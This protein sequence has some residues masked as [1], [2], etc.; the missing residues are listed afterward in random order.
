VS[1]DTGTATLEPAAS[2]GA[3]ARKASGLV[4]SFSQTDALFYNILAINPFL[5]SALT[6]T[7]MVVAFPGASPWLAVLICGVLC[8][9][10]AVVYAYLTTM[11]PRSGGDYVFQSRVIGGAAAT[12][13]TLSGIVIAEIA[14]ILL[15]TSVGTSVIFAPFLTLLGAYY[16]SD[17]LT[18]VGTWLGTKAGFII[19]GGVVLLWCAY[20]NIR[21]LQ[22]YARVQRAVFVVAAGGLAAVFLI[23]LF[24][25]H[26]DFVNGL[27]SFMADH[28]GVHD[29][30]QTVLDRGSL[31]S[32]FSFSA[33]MTATVLAAF[34]F[35]FP[36]WGVMQAGEIKRAGATRGNMYA[37]LGAEIIS[38]GIALASVLLL[39]G[40]V[41]HD[42][43]IASGDLAFN[44]PGR[45]PLPVDPFF[46][47]FASVIHTSPA[48]AWLVFITAL[49]WFWMW[50]PNLLVAVTRVLLAL[51]FDRL[52]PAWLSQVGRRSHAPVNA[53]IATSVACLFFLI[54]YVFISD[55]I[56]LVAS[57]VMLTITT[58]AATMVAGGLMPWLRPD[59]FSRA[60]DAVQRRVLGLP[61]ITICAAIFFAYAVYVDYS[62]LTQDALGVNTTKG[63]VFVGGTYALSAAAYIAAVYYRRRQKIDVAVAYKEL[64]IE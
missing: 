8:I 20:I 45:N 1:E 46:G 50:V 59:L 60:P 31:S 38:I 22:I 64:P 56:T 3:F 24:S 4:R 49:A 44:H 18:D 27:N 6:F 53:I 36:A 57:F 48:L 25:S 12:F 32:S 42:F 17:A 54:G 63:L 26:G 35:I 30:Y 61:I 34:A 5:V 40:R 28:Y 14:A 47:F 19:F 10:E 41:G 16:N 9:P 62:C 29:A 2:E 11:M 43:F 51:S 21:G 33:T 52:A 39:V 37:I 23:M 7:T 58:F 15:V 55:L 13:F